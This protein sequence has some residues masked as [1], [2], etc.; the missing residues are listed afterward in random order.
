MSGRP[1]AKTPR[2]KC[3]PLC[4]AMVARFIRAQAAADFDGDV[5]RGRDPPDEIRVD[6]L[7]LKGAVKVHDVQPLGALPFPVERRV[8]A[9]RGP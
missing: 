6:R 3:R 7:P 2:G 1:S 9:R 5:Q 8:A 4:R